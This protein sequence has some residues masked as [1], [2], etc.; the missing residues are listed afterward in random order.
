MDQPRNDGCQVNF[1]SYAQLSRDI[2]DWIT[3]LPRDIDAVLGVPRSGIAPASMLALFRNIKLGDLRG[4]F[5]G[6]HRDPRVS[7]KKALVLDDSSLTG[8][9]LLRARAR[10]KDLPFKCIYGAVYASKRA[11]PH[12]DVYYKILPTPRIF[13][14]NLLHHSLL[15]KSCV[16]IDGV[17]CVDPT[18]RENDD[19]PRYLK[20]LKS[21][22]PLYIPTVKVAALVTNRLERYRK[23]TEEWLA[24]HGVDYGQLIM[25]PA[26]SKRERQTWQGPNHKSSVYQLTDHRLFIESSDKQAKRIA[27]IT[28]KPVICTDTME[29]FQ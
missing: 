15:S 23:P 22:K 24:M 29:L 16:D 20:F 4:C 26:K 6:G 1:V 25:H 9:S 11:A 14:W 8:K 17:L 21:A 2:A 13:E 27:E 28:G 12:L 7:I 3:R 5:K 18:Q 10:T 19:G